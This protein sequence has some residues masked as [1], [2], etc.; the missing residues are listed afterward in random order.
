MAQS[1]LDFAQTFFSNFYQL[2]FGF[3]SLLV[4]VTHLQFGDMTQFHL[5]TCS[6]AIAIRNSFEVIPYIFQCYIKM[7]STSLIR[8]SGQQ[9]DCRLVLSLNTR[10]F[11]L[12]FFVSNLSC[13]PHQDYLTKACTFYY[14]TPSF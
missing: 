3:L 1:S 12:F 13:S 6:S 14:L 11:I 7:S 5:H 8:Y 4:V 2:I 10:Q 9:N